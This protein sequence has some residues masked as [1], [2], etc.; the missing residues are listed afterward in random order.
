MR[1]LLLINL[2]APALC[3]GGHLGP[4]IDITV[5]IQQVA[6]APGLYLLKWDDTYWSPIDM[7][8]WCMDEVDEDEYID[9]CCR[10]EQLQMDG[11]DPEIG[12]NG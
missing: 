5:R 7:L 11:C 12:L 4:P 2:L 3:F 8:V 10:F 9:P 1:K 6:D